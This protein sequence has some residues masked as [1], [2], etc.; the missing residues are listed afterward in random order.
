MCN[1]IFIVHSLRDV[2]KMNAY[3]SRYVCLSV[4]PHN[5]PR[6]QLEEFG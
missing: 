1:Y 4:C 6:E 3:R 2:H 5:S